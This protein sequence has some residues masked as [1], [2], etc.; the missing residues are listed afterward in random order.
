MKEKQRLNVVKVGG[1]ILENE[2]DL[3]ELLDAFCAIPGQNILVHGGGRSATELAEKLGIEAPMH[4]G[5]R[6]TNADMLEVAIMVYGGLVNKR[7]VAHL[8]ARDKQ[9]VGLTGADLNI[10][11]AHKR[12]SD[13]VDYGFAG[14]IDSV[15]GES[16]QL[17]LAGGIVPVLAPLTHNGQGQLLNTNADTIAATVAQAM[18]SS[19][20]VHLVFCFEKAGVLLNPDDDSSLLTSLDQVAFQELVASGDISG[21]MI[22]K[23]TN[24]FT[25]IQRGVTNVWIG[26]FDQLPMLHTD[27]YLGTRIS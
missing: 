6:L 13:Q 25:A 2:A 5:R 10:I 22:P 18:S 23:L 20:E 9:A 8:Q 11:L 4:E 7:V 27:A 15:Q 1:K 14:D 24:A 19:W 26:K 21:G 16:L 3:G 17:L 12:I